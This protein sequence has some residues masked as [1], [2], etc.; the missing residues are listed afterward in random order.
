MMGIVKK[1]YHV[2]ALVALLGVVPLAATAAILATSGRLTGQKLEQI[3][4][5]LREDGTDEATDA[6]DQP[7]EAAEPA[8]SSV[9][10][11]P[12][13]D[14][15][16]EAELL[17]REAQRVRTELD[18][19]LAM[20]NRVLLDVQQQRKE[21]EEQQQMAARALQQ[22]E[23]SMTTEGFQ[24]Q[25]EY[26]MSLSPKVALDH[27]LAAPDPADAARMLVAMDTRQGKKIIES[28]RTGDQQEQMRVIM[29]KMREVAPDRVDD[30]EETP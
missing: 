20:V 2:V 16:T 21:F 12:E 9:A 27:L 26:L 4:A 17:H 11:E 29:Q 22:R 1:L 15:R 19:R 14:P 13:L 6:E 5:V 18:Q 23:E 25:L 10:A 3:A 8:E 24:K 7:A 30:L 28:A